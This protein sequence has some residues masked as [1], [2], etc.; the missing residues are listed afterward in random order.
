MKRVTVVIAC[1]VGL[2]N[3]SAKVA[4][5]TDNIEYKSPA[6]WVLPPPTATAST[7]STDAAVRFDYLDNQVRITP[8]GTD[9]EYTAFRLKIMKPE[10][11]AA[12]NLSLG[13]QPDTG[14]MTV[15]YVRLIHNGHVTDVLASTKFIILQREAHLE[16]SVLTGLRTATLQV[17]GL[18]VGDE[19]ELAVT[20]DKRDPGLN[21]RVAGL[22][23]FP[24]AGTPGTF[25]FR[26]IWPSGRQLE[27]RAT[28]DM[29]RIEPTTADGRTTLEVTLRDPSGVIPTEGAPVRYNV[30]RLIEYSDFRSWPDVSSQLAPMF[31]RAA[32]L[33][34]KSDIKA[35]A[36]AIAARTRDPIERA[37]AALQ[38][39]EDRIRYVFIALNGGSYIP[40][41]AEETWGRRFG[42]CKAKTVLLVALLRELG[43][44]A[45][46]A[47]VNSQGGDGLDERLPGPRVFDHMITRAVVSGRVVWLD[48]TRVGDRY[49]DNLPLPYRWALPLTASGA[50][51]EKIQPHEDGFPS[52]IGIVDIDATAGFNQDAHVHLR[53][54]VRGDEAFVVRSKLA[55]MT[56]DDADRA[57]KSY[58]HSQADWVTPSKVLW[59]Y[60]ERRRAIEL[61]L[62][63]DGNPGWKGDDQSGHSWTIVGAGFYPPAPLRRPADQD[64]SAPWSVS[65]PRFRC[66]ATT[67]H[68]PKAGKNFGWSLYAEPMN[69]RLGGILYWRNSGFSGNIVRTVMST[70]SYE[71]EAT[72]EEAAVVNRSIPNFNNNMSSIAEE[73]PANVIQGV[74]PTLPFDD[75]V[76]WL[77][78]PSPCSPPNS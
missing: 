23:Q 32:T 40:A 55:A 78:A 14:G 69:Q 20:I 45:E 6:S 11:L 4:A 56:P 52:L 25:R 50:T 72:P 27:W 57:L 28:K 9:E 18:Q 76:D 17:P 36:A 70:H 41:T 46:P 21:G 34:A 3:V 49:L 58:W 63:G 68:L 35:E 37:Q 77:N 30:H 59:R 1:I 15:H 75:K 67:I 2:L 47:L 26:L 10:G 12:G 16:Q 53:N 22:M 61:D 13:W 33:A 62:T 64:Q 43:I 48:A 65:Y 5:A 42:D 51:L 71:L 29:L 19:L 7:L 73:S 54:I 39:V 60:D 24:V 44:E 31:E 74:S 38:L 66:W 8:D